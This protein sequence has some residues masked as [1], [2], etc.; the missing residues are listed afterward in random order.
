M[1]LVIVHLSLRRLLEPGDNGV[2]NI[3]ENDVYFMEQLVENISNEFNVNLDKVY[4]CGYSNGGM[5]AYS[6]ACNSSELFAGIGIMSGALL[7]DNCT[8]Q[9]PVP[10]IK[11][12]GVADEVL[13]YD[14]SVWYQSVAEVVRFW[15]DRNQI[16][17][18]NIRTEMLN[19][20]NVV[21]DEYF[22][23]NSCFTLYTIHEEFDKPGD[24]VWFSDE[25][26]GVSPNKIMWDFLNESCSSLSSSVNILNEVSDLNIF[27]NPFSDR[28][29]ITTNSSL[30]DQEYIIYDVN[31]TRLVSG[32]MN[33]ETV[34]L[35]LES[36]PP[37]IYLLK[38]GNNIRKLL[39][40]E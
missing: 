30:I 1:A 18:N 26:D 13:P 33:T 28:I 20:G 35:K 29:N 17:E 22:G 39:K 16:P 40:L 24:H 5:M 10:I 3:Y 38:I 14:G 12:H 9:N 25:I 23:D 31:G 7:D 4:A 6:L 36:L 2:N 19:D 8:L 11:F 32:K 15:L 27:P 34:K 37:N 21:R